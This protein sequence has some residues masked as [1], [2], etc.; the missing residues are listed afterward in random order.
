MN[1][2]LQALSTSQRPL[3][4][5]VVNLAPDSF[6]DGGKLSDPEAAVSQA[7]A[8]VGQGADILDIGGEST[9]PGAAPVPVEEELARVMPVVEALRP[10][11][12][13][14]ITIDTRKPEVARAAIRAGAD[15]WNDVSALTYAEDSLC[16]AVSLAVPVILM[17]AQGT[18][19]TMQH[20]PAYG[21]VVRDVRDFLSRRIAACVAAGLSRSQLIIDPGIG[22]G[23]TL[24]HNLALMGGLDRL[25]QLGLPILVGASRKRFIQALD[26]SA[27]DPLDRLG[28][29]IAAALAA[30]ASGAQILR[31]HD[32]RETAQ[33]LVVSSAIAQYQTNA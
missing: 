19:E 10:Q 27:S 21:D 16:T 8:L 24:E 4:M 11:T 3:I 30:A 2:L 5:G 13:V 18:P 33:G 28:G 26:V 25:Q 23:K 31:V 15:A 6:S 12:D 9:R 29:S 7:L 17:H 1:R 14:P 22:F 32:V 20:N